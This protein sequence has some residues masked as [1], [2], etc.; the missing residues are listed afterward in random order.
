MSMIKANCI[1]QK[2]IF[3]ICILLVFCGRG[4]SSDIAVVTMVVSND[5]SK[6]TQLGTVSKKEY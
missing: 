6:N 5:Y 4:M 2:I 3:F 1:L